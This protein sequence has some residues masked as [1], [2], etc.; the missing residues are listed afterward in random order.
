MRATVATDDVGKLQV[1]FYPDAPIP[2]IAQVDVSGNEAVDKGVI[3][4]AANDVAIGVPLTDARV[5]MI[6]MAQL[7]RSTQLA[8]IR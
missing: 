1:N 7:S 8:D 6:W 3:L 2:T 5:K 4:R